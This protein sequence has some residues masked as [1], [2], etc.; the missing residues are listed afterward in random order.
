V[1]GENGG[2]LVET[3]LSLLLLFVFIFGIMELSLALYSYHFVSDAAR[4]GTRYAIVRGSDWANPCDTGN[5]GTGY[6]SAA[7]NASVA[8]IQAYVSS[9]NFPGIF[10][11][12][13]DVCVE[14]FSTPP[15]SASSSCT[16]S[17]G[18]LTNANG[19]VVQVTVTYPFT[20]GL[21]GLSKFT[22]SLAST[23]QMVISQ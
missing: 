21:P 5:A 13:Q 4:E 23:S 14:F 19:N 22:Y 2:T 1:R 3:A 11:T 7:C 20:F 17:S 12:T 16:N 10:L 6:T 9:L 18:T 15:T 8:D